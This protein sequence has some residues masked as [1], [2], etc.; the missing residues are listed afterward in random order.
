MILVDVDMGC[1]VVVIDVCLLPQVTR[2][3]IPTPMAKPQAYLYLMVGT[4]DK[5]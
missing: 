2:R 5:V 4:F 3:T 1:Y